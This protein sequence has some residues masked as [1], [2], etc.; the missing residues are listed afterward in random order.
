VD[1][2]AFS[3]ECITD[4]LRHFIRDEV[5]DDLESLVK[6]EADILVAKLCSRVSVPRSVTTSIIQDFSSFFTSGIIDKLKKLVLQ[7]LEDSSVSEVE[8]T[9]IRGVF[10]VLSNP[11]KHIETDFL[12]KR[13]FQKSGC[14]VPPQS[15]VIHSRIQRVKTP[16]GMKLQMRDV[17]G[18]FISVREVLKKLFELPDVFETVFAYT[19]SLKEEKTF[20]NFMQSECFKR[21]LALYP[22]G[23]LVLPLNFYEDD[24]EPNAALGTHS[25]K[26]GAGYV[27]LP[28][29]PPHCRS[30]LTNI[31]L[32]LLFNADDRKLY[33]NKKVFKP[34]IEEF[35]FLSSTGLSVERPDGSVVRLFFVLGLLTGDNL[36]LNGLAGFVE[37]F[38]AKFFCRECKVSKCSSESLVKEMPELV[39]TSESYLR[40][41]LIGDSTQTG[42]K[43][44]CVFEGVF[45]FETPTD[46]GFDPFHDLLE[47]ACHYS[48]K[49]ILKHF[50]DKEKY[51]LENL[52]DRMYLFNFLKDS[53]NEPPSI[54]PEWL[55]GHNKLKMTGAEMFT[56]V[57]LLG[58]IIGDLIKEGD[59]FWTLYLLLHDIVIICNSKI[60]PKSI[61]RTLEYLV[62]EHHALYIELTKETLKPKHHFLI[63]LEPLSLRDLRV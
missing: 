51:F 42:V 32:A 23:T 7:L 55:E 40:D 6:G 5:T 13:H 50:H 25:E 37:S 20:S 54:L 39:R 59:R 10:N 18:Q 52:N 31:L 56:F 27:G 4:T 47:G 21:K 11:F 61:G 58:V 22:A 1:E 24:F 38:S 9:K 17:T 60:L 30:K 53:D 49:P 33:G 35:N 43:E 8:K 28:F 16:D 19:T 14:Y 41:V 3:S 26:L 34:L 15:Y 46:V 12:R 45:G 29:L 44:M 48:L 57:R 2:P 62:Q 63:T 36:A